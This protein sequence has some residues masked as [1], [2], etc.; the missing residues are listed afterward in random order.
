MALS[1]LIDGFP[2]G[3]LLLCRAKEILPGIDG[4]LLDNIV[5]FMTYS[6]VPAYLVYTTDLVPAGW[7]A[8]IAIMHPGRPP[9]SSFA[10]RTPRRAT[11]STKA[12]LLLEYRRLRHDPAGLAGRL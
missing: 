2:T 10:R 12:S 1:I 11:T 4:S 6:V 3:S 9:P 7:T 8:P 5:D